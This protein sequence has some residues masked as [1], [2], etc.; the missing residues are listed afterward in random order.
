MKLRFM[1]GYV[2]SMRGIKQVLFSL[3]NN[4]RIGKFVKVAAEK[5]LIKKFHNKKASAVI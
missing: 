4:Y 2:A 3:L 1:F 5:M